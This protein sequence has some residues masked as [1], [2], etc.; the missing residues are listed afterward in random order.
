MLNLKRQIFN[1]EADYSKVK[2]ISIYINQLKDFIPI[3]QNNT[4]IIN[5]SLEGNT[6]LGYEHEIIRLL[7]T[8][9]IRAINL[10]N[11][12]KNNMIPLLYI[13]GKGIKNN[14]TLDRLY[15]INGENLSFEKI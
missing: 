9:K 11:I 14:K 2:T 12:K 3:I 15:V 8:T 6:I 1:I 4:N 13:I 5:I 10:N 7:Q